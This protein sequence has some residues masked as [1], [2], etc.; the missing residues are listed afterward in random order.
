MGS[1][2]NG[3]IWM[4]TKMWILSV[5]QWLCKGFANLPAGITNKSEDV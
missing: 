5:A 1:L 4:L 2:K 3:V